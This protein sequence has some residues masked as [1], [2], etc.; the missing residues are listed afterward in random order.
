MG[1]AVVELGYQAA[2][3]PERKGS[4]GSFQ[5]M[6]WWHL[7]IAFEDSLLQESYNEINI[8][9]VGDVLMS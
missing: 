3:L 1:L 9:T 5:I 6:K 4:P 8:Y 2:V 7:Y